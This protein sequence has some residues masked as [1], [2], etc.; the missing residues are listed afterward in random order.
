MT[1]SQTIQTI[2]SKIRQDKR[3]SPAEAL[4]LLNDAPWLEIAQLAWE[5]RMEIIGSETASY[6]VFRII[7]YTNVCSIQCSFC[8]FKCSEEDDKAYVLSQQQV[9][10]LIEQAREKGSDQVFFQGGVNPSLPLDYY[11]EVLSG[12]KSRYGFHIRGFSPVELKHM[13]ELYNLDIKDL[14]SELKDAGLGSVPGAGAEILVERVR[15][16]LAPQKCTTDEWVEIMKCCHQH[17]LYG[18]ANI[19]FGSVESNEEIIEHLDVVRNIQDETGGFNSFIPWTFQSQTKDFHRRAVKHH[20][21][22]KVL[23]LCRLFL[24]NIDN[25]E[26]SVMVL[27]KEIGQLALRMG[28]NDISSP[29]LEEKVLRSFGVRNE[30][31]SKAL[32]SAAGFKPVRRDFT[33]QKIQ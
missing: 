3:I 9:F 15:K 32:I 14:I 19:V 33:Y 5:R 6:T 27:G 8:S 28:A 2:Y 21:Y 31:E 30:E 7:N 29:V 10:E 11:L 26:V 25:L 1:T 12:I 24:D 18:S 17:G 23:A 20:E 22:L 4:V 16:I 13:A